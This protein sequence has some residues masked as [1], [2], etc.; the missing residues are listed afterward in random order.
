MR[1]WSAWAGMAT[2]LA[3]LPALAVA[4]QRGPVQA[5][6]FLGASSD[7]RPAWADSIRV[8]RTE[9]GTVPGSSPQIVILSVTARNECRRTLYFDGVGPATPALWT[10]VSDETAWRLLSLSCLSG[11]RAHTLAPGRE[12]RY[13]YSTTAD[14]A[15]LVVGIVVSVE[16]EE[17]WAVATP[18]GD[19]GAFGALAVNPTT[20][21]ALRVSR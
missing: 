18:L 9:R 8:I 21:E 19:K 11:R 15:D 7:K 20:A 12:L 2:L 14:E 16:G 5:C 3:A 17:T 10:P 13:T 4:P 1:S 6:Q